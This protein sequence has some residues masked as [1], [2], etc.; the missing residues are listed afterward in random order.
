MSPAFAHNDYVVSFGCRLTRYCVGDVVV[1]KH[2]SL[3]VIIKRIIETDGQQRV[4]LAGDNPASTDSL[5]IGWQPHQ[6]LIGKVYWHIA[7]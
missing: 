7:A 4:L 1:V 5:T 2:P 6:Q 3:G